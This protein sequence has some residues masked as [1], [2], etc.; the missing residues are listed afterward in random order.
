MTGAT[1]EAVIPPSQN[2]D[3]PSSAV[4]GDHSKTSIKLASGEVHSA[5]IVIGADGHQSIVR[6][7]IEEVPEAPRTGRVVYNGVIPH[8]TMMAD[9]RLKEVTRI[10]FPV[11]MGN[12]YYAHCKHSKHLL[13]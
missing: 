2:S 11:W 10:G 8:A 13:V 9:E 12:L 1:V 4:N 5:D 6:R 3:S 7:T